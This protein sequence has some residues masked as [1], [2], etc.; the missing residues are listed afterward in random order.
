[1]LPKR[2]TVN[3]DGNGVRLCIFNKNESGTLGDITGS[4][5]RVDC[6]IVNMVNQSRGD[7][8]YNVIDLDGVPPP[9]INDELM[10]MDSVLRIRLIGS[11]PAQ[12]EGPH[13]ISEP[14]V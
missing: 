1:M 6:N 8:A 12:F 13:S 4:L 2:G 10:E 9:V 14:A 5:G 3:T 11:T 7:Y